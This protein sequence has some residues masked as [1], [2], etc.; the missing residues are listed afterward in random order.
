M[1]SINMK[2]VRPLTDEE[3]AE[4]VAFFDRITAAIWKSEDED[5]L[6][7]DFIDYCKGRKVMAL[8]EA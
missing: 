3:A 4:Q 5:P 7:E 8:E 2:D 6:P 1:L